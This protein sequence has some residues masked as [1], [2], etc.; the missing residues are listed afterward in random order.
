MDSSGPEFIPDT[1]MIVAAQ[2]QGD[3]HCRT[4]P[5]APPIPI[6]RSITAFVAQ[7]S[8]FVRLPLRADHSTQHSAVAVPTTSAIA[9]GSVSDRPEPAARG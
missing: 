3:P 2:S 8:A 6:R 7:I 4:G 5:M 9:N 1:D